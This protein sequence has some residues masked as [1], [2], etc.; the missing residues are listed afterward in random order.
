MAVQEIIQSHHLVCVVMELAERGD[1]LE[2][3]KRNG[4]IPDFDA[5]RMFRQVRYGCGWILPSR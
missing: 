3:I 5:K 1:L 4:A 2:H